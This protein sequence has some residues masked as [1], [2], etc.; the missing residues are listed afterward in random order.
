MGPPLRWVSQI[1]AR[2]DFL[3]DA[4]DRLSVEIEERIAPLARERDLLVTIPRVQ[5]W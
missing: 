5:R 1:L 3:D 4:I 2:L